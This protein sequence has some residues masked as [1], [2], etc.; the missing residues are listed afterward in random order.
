M[1]LLEKGWRTDIQVMAELRKPDRSKKRKRSSFQRA[2][3]PSILTE[4]DKLKEILKS[5]YSKY[6]DTLDSHALQNHAENTSY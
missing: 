3:F 4:D 1:Y 6:L 5:K 2:S